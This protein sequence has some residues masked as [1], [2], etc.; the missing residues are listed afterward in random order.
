VLA[1]NI[2]EVFGEGAIEAGAGTVNV[3]AAG[4]ALTTKFDD[5]AAT[6]EPMAEATA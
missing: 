5:A 6:S 3:G 1:E 2:E 4:P